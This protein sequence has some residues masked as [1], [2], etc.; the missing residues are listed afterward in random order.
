MLLT[1]C[2]GWIRKKW[3]ERSDNCEWEGWKDAKWEINGSVSEFERGW[4]QEPLDYWS[5]RE[6]VHL[7]LDSCGVSTLTSG[8]NIPAPQ[9]LNPYSLCF[10]STRPAGRGMK[11]KRLTGP[12]SN[13]CDKTTKLL[14][15]KLRKC[16][17]NTIPNGRYA[18]FPVNYST[19][20]ALLAPYH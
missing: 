1:D 15:W 10:I 11:N 5:L 16:N 13:G 9:Q 7:T 14:T 2:C 3:C 4:W 12:L 19:M 8:W 6:P 17:L 20:D 18:I